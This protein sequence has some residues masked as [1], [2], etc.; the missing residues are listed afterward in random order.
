MASLLYTL[1]SSNSDEGVRDLKA[2]LKTNLCDR[3]GSLEASEI[4]ALATLLDPRYKNFVFRDDICA[5]DAEIKL[6]A[7]LNSEIILA[8]VLEAESSDANRVEIVK[9]Q[10][11]SQWFI[12]SDG[13]H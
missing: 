1:K 13:S 6:L 9:Q 12:C 5:K 11:F 2:R 10:Y 7:K 8:E 3:L 4:H